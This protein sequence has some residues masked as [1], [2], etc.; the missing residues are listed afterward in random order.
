M[1]KYR[2]GFR[3]V[4]F[5]FNIFSKSKWT[6]FLPIVGCRAHSDCP[7]TKECRNAQCISPCE[8]KNPCKDP[9]E[10]RVR[11][12]NAYCISGEFCDSYT[13]A[14]NLLRVR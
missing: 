9:E 6:I 3:E 8:V 10:C 13:K 7:A 1:S 12:H 14:A 4:M 5:T 11:D 2:F